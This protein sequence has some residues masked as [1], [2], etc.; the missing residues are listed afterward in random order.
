MSRAINFLQVLPAPTPQ[1]SPANFEALLRAI[2]TLQQNL[3][4]PGE[5]R[6]TQLTLTDLPTS[7]QGLEGGALYRRGSQVFVTLANEA[8]LAGNNSTGSVGSVTVVIR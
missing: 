6:G 3:Q 2:N 4:N 1:Y 8:A 7:D 5:M